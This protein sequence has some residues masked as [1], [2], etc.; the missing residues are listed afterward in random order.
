[1]TARAGLSQSCSHYSS[2]ESCQ[3]GP[4][5]PPPPTRRGPASP[6]TRE[7]SWPRRFVV[8]GSLRMA[9][10]SRPRPGWMLPG[11]QQTPPQGRLGR[12]QEAGRGAQRRAHPRRGGPRGGEGGGRTQG[13][14]GEGATGDRRGRGSGAEGQIREEANP[15][16]PSG[17]KREQPWGGGAESMLKWGPGPWGGFREVRPFHPAPPPASRKGLQTLRLPPG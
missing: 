13:Q 3:L 2:R 8:R 9:G 4:G 6:H 14:K 1:M 5:H 15:G 11:S 12:M 17:R 16:R 10:L 7:G